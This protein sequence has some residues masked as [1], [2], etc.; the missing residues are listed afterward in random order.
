MSEP[1][2]RQNIQG[3]HSLSTATGDIYI[4]YQHLP[5]EAEDY[6][7]LRTLL[8]RVKRFWIENVLEQ[9]LHGAA[10]LELGKKIRRDTIERPWKMVPEVPDET[11]QLL[12]PEQKMVDIFNKD[13][14]TLLIL[15]KPGSGKT[16]TLLEL[17][18]DLIT[19]AENDPCQPIPVVFN[20]STWTKGQ[21]LV[22][23]LVSE[24][25]A[26]YHIPKRFGR[27]WLDKSRLVLLLDGLDEVTPDHRTACVQAINDFVEEF[28]VAGL[29]VCSR[30]KAYTA[31]PVRLNFEGAICLQP[32]TLKQVDDYLSAAG[33]P[34]TS[35]RMALQTDRPLRTL[36]R[37]PLMLSIMSLAYQDLPAEHLADATINTL[38]KRRQHLFDTYIHRMFARKGK[39]NS[40]YAKALTQ[41]W[42]SWLARKMRQHSQ[43]IFL[44]EQLQPNWLPTQQQQW[45]YAFCSS[46]MAGLI[47]GL[48][49]GLI[50][51]LVWG[52]QAMMWAL[53]PM[54]G[55]V[56]GLLDTFRFTS[57]GPSRKINKKYALW[58]TIIDILGAALVVG[59]SGGLIGE[60]IL[61]ANH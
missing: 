58:Q 3:H 53:V 47:F 1:T 56:G 54:V 5:A 50:L 10:L 12:S 51:E 6:S 39:A 45:L 16:V 15:G 42:L 28:G 7:N 52:V 25:T 41:R 34:L 21:D 29:A 31:L 43:S 24:L 35:L 49:G 55:L 19:Y 61:G 26:K 60:Q 27:D 23:W 33:S 4:E 46:L 18:R 11:P 9:S 57:I 40:P 48:S 14:P 8:D 59:L 13:G 37:S 32:L 22:N 2:I 30:L 17:A 44:I 20:L 36:A 38:E